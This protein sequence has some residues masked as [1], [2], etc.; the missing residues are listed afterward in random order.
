MN[1]TITGLA[2]LVCSGPTTDGSLRTESGSFRAVSPNPPNADDFHNGFVSSFMINGV[3]NLS[4]NASGN[5]IIPNS[6]KHK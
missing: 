2:G 1:P 3:S 5:F 4:T 6:K